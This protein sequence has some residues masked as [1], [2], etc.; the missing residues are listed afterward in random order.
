MIWPWT[1]VKKELEKRVLEARNSSNLIPAE[2]VFKYLHNLP[3]Q[4]FF[5]RKINNLKYDLNRFA[6][7]LYRFFNPCH[8]KIRKCIPRTW[9]DLDEI[10]RTVNFTALT[11]FYE[12]EY[13][14]YVEDKQFP[15]HN[16]E[17]LAFDKWI[18]D[19]YLYIT[20]ERQKLYDKIYEV[21]CW[22]IE[23]LDEKSQC[24][25]LMHKRELELESKD[26]QI[27][28]EIVANRLKFWS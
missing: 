25:D 15:H 20:E 10:I 14:G 1:N 18:K 8:K 6:W 5:V 16:E 28:K 7:D 13:D 12:D 24:Y 11:E 9:V 3:K 27:L 4:N 26:T 21:S 17:S 19:A 2:D 23:N 22:D